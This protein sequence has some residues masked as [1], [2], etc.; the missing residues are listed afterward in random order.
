M[1]DP[2]TRQQVR[3][4]AGNCCEY[5]GRTQASSTF[6]LQVEHVIPKKHGGSDEIVNL[7]LACCDC[8][9]AKG[10]NLAGRESETG[11]LVPLF[12][13]RVQSWTEHFE[14][15]GLLILGKTDIGRATADVLNFNTED[16]V[17]QR[18]QQQT[19]ELG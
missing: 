8:N 10:P 16:R 4:R 19:E 1:I 13:P 12:N 11:A 17:A 6:P 9:L 15:R 5:C 3:E 18:A 7:A 2:K 14:R